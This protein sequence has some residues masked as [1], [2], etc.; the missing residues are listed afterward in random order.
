MTDT[1]TSGQRSA[2]MARIKSRRTRPEMRVHG[3]LK[4]HR[5]RHQMW[6]ALPGRP[7]AIAGR[8]AVFVN[9]CFWHGCA[10]CYQ[11]PK[12]NREFWRAK[13]RRNRARQRQVTGLLRKLGISVLVLWEHDIM[14]REGD[15]FL[16]NVAKKLKTPWKRR[17]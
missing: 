6:P 12:S 13:I 5:V 2:H 7:D 1:M 17:S 8:T 16:S 10:R 4:G 15:I 14:R 11:E 3:F 9:G